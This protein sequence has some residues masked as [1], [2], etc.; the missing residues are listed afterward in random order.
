MNGTA[1]LFVERSPEEVFA[2]VA[3]LENAPDW[4]PDLVS[5]SKTSEGNVGVGTRYTEVVK[6]GERKN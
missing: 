2:Y 3:N 1:S 5:V 4:V 6:M